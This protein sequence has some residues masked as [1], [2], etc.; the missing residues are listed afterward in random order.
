MCRRYVNI[1]Y[2]KL[3]AIGNNLATVQLPHLGLAKQCK[4]KQ[5][6]E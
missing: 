5:K 6:L 2:I 3:S 1:K 4:H